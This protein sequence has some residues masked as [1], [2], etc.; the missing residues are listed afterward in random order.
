[1]SQADDSQ[2]SPKARDYL[3]AWMKQISEG[4]T[5]MKG[6]AVSVETSAVPGSPPDGG[7]WIRVFGGKAGEHAF[8][9]TAEDARSLARAFMGS[10]SETEAALNAETREAVAQFFEQIATMIPARE[11]LGTAGELRVSQADQPAWEIVDQAAFRF[12]TSEGPLFDLRAAISADFLAALEGAE[13]SAPA[14][15]RQPAAPARDANLDLL[16]DVELEVTLRFG[17]REMLLGDIL[18]LAPGS[19][20]ELDQNVSDPVELLVGSKVIAW[21]EVVT[22][23]GNYGLRV[24]GLASREERLESLRG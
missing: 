3:S 17:Q 22:V 11:W 19:V 7:M 2:L 16:L 18:K 6:H 15:K 4:L 21:G 5:R 1:M 10:S 8:F 20:V 9:L 14:A 13:S 12:N 23:D 24:T